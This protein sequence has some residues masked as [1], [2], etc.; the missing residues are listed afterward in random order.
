[1]KTLLINSTLQSGGVCVC[2][3]ACAGPA[4]WHSAVSGAKPR[5]NVQAEPS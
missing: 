3:S 5:P 2:L 4:V 1:M